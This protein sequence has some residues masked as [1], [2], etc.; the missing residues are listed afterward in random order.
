MA[1]FATIVVLSIVLCIVSAPNLEA[2]VCYTWTHYGWSACSTGV[3]S[4][5]ECEEICENGGWDEWYYIWRLSP[6]HPKCFDNLPY[7]RGMAWYEPWSMNVWVTYRYVV[8]TTGRYKD[9]HPSGWVEDWK[10][11]CGWNNPWIDPSLY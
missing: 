11:N 1:R 2:G 6:P 9:T 3:A 7:R 4:E 5:S 10:L 8:I